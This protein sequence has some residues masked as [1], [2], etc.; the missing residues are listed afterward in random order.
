[1]P[2]RLRLRHGSGD[3]PLVEPSISPRPNVLLASNFFLTLG[4]WPGVDLSCHGRERDGE[5]TREH[6]MFAM[7]HATSDYKLCATARR[8]QV[9]EHTQEL[10]SRS[11]PKERFGSFNQ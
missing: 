7:G 3:S 5:E 10:G 8:D 6:G 1:M 9:P 2:G 11:V 4:A